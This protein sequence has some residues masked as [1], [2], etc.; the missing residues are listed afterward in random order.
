MSFLPQQL[1]FFVGGIAALTL[2]INATT[3]Q[4]VLQSLGLLKEADDDKLLVMD[5]IRKSLRKRVFKQV[6]IVQKH[7]HIDSADKIIKYN[8]LLREDANQWESRGRTSRLSRDS[9]VDFESSP[10]SRSL[11][12]RDSGAEVLPDLLSYVRTVF[13]SIV[14]VEYWHRIEDGS[15]PREAPAT[16]SLLYSIDNAMDRVHK[17]NLRDWK[18]LKNEMQPMK[19]VEKLTSCLESRTDVDAKIHGFSDVMKSLDEEFKVYVLTTFIECHE[20]AQRKIYGFVGKEMLDALENDFRSPEIAIVRRESAN[21]VTQAI[22]LLSEIDSTIISNIT[23]RQA[24]TSIL[25][26]QSQYLL[27]MVKEGLLTPQD[28]DTFFAEIHKDRAFIEKD[29]VRH[30]K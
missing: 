19:I 29:R 23:C 25:T 27:Q 6:E 14:R 26:M 20:T 9:S 17:P 24:A 10:S 18:W 13:L 21:H 8:S 5:Q 16:Q 2:I 28:T 7:L 22:A 1:F 15:L 3:A 11:S 12:R 4:M 30:F